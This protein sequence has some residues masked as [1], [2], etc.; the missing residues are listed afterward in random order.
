MT[1]A[2]SLVGLADVH[3]YRATHQL[4]RPSIEPPKDLRVTYLLT[5]PIIHFLA[6]L[7]DLLTCLL[8]TTDQTFSLSSFPLF[9]QA[10]LLTINRTPR[11]RRGN[12]T[13]PVVPVRSHPIKEPLCFFAKNLQLASHS[14][15]GSLPLKSFINNCLSTSDR[16]PQERAN[17]DRRS[18][19][20][21]PT[22]SS[23][24]LFSPC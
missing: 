6:Y 17:S 18:E 8:S 24:F 10:L 11:L 20:K 3:L 5:I 12:Y 9:A 23:N 7:L 15:T 22:G 2:F 21:P 1:R 13:Y 19:T 16:V 4:D 14:S